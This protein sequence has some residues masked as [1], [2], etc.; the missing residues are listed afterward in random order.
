M[1]TI[2][3]LK[4]ILKETLDER[5]ILQKV[6]AQIRAEIF[7]TLNEQVSSKKTLSE[8]N[9]IINEIFRE[10]L[11]YNN[12]HHTKEVFIPETGQ[13]VV[14]P[15]RRDYIAKRLKVVEDPKARDLPLI[16]VINK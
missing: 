2:E 1:A 15:F 12:Y 14:P 3:E 7:N 9:L 16:Y 11:E 8:E 5:G 6:R 10:Y 4:D 13:P